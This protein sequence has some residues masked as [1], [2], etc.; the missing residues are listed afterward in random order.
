MYTICIFGHKSSQTAAKKHYLH[1]LNVHIMLRVV[2]HDIG[3]CSICSN[4]CR[5][6]STI[7][8]LNYRNKY[9]YLICLHYKYYNEIAEQT[10]IYNRFVLISLRNLL[11]SSL[12]KDDYWCPIDWALP[13]MTNDPQI[14]TISALM[15][16]PASLK[17][18]HNNHLNSTDNQHTQSSIHNNKKKKTH[19][20]CD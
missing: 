19:I 15:S 17:K 1:Y 3:H 13:K 4:S 6:A 14:V 5:V 20:Q 10:H 8:S 11:K 16:E 2:N 12:L 18:R 7:S 9:L